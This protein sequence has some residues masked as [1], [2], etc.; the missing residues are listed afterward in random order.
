MM[1]KCIDEIRHV[2]ATLFLADF[3]EAIDENNASRQHKLIQYDAMEHFGFDWT[4]GPRRKTS[5]IVGPIFKLATQ[6][7]QESPVTANLSLPR[8]RIN[9]EICCADKNWQ[10]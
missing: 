4:E 10:W 6:E 9:R 2:F 7:F 8:L 3:V 1:K 5:G